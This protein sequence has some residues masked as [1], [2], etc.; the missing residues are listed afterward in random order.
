MPKT[1]LILGAG[2]GGIV[3]AHEI[4]KQLPKREMENWR[5]LI[6]EKEER[7]VF[8]PSLLWLMV[9]MRKPSQISRPVENLA[10]RNIQVIRGTIEKVDPDSK[11]IQVNGQEY[12]GD[13]I[14]ISLGAE[15]STEHNLREFGSDFYTLEGAAEFYKKLEGFKGGKIVVLIPSLPF[16]CPAAPY[17][18]AMLIHNF[19]NKKGL[20]EKTEVSVYTPEPGPMP[21]A[22]KEISNQVKLTVE[23]K[24]IKYF[25]EHQLTEVNSSTLVFQNGKTAQYDL[26]AYT[27]RHKCPAAI[28]ATSLA[29]NSGW[30]EVNRH[31]L[32]TKYDGIYAIGDITFIPLEIGKSL[33]KA[34]VFAHY[35]AEVVANN[36]VQKILGNKADKTFNGD[37]QCFL[38]MGKDIAGFAGL[39]QFLRDFFQLNFR[40]QISELLYISLIPAVPRTVL[41]RE[42]NL[43]G[44]GLAI[45]FIK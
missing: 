42:R 18:A 37:G 4:A 31:T 22:G 39:F 3:T 32:E 14:V 38:E 35:Q 34:G 7:S 6:F 8:A 23:S 41:P 2:T 13:Y 17:E 9:G 15:Q 10:R 43:F 24:G 26:L 36:I 25:P 28:K 21:V 45:N 30:V 27:P 19:I 1:I 20:S 44:Q 12:E 33:P 11:T 16:K 5:I 29:G 40:E